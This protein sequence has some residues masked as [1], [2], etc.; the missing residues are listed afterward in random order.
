MKKLFLP[1]IIAIIC[2]NN[3]LKAQCPPNATAFAI[4]YSLCIPEPGCAVLL[5]G[6][7]KG[8]LVNIFGGTP[9]Q[10]I[11]TVQIPGTYPEPG[12]DNAFVC[13][14]CNVPLVFA[15]TV[16]GATNGCVITSTITTPVKLMGFSVN[17]SANGY[18]KIIWSAPSETGTEKYIVE[19]SLDSRTFTELT[20]IIPQRTGTVEHNY[21]YTDKISNQQQLY[22][23]IKTVEINGKI[24]YSE[25]AA[26]KK[27]VDAGVSI[28]PNPVIN[29]FKVNISAQHLPAMVKIFNA[30]GEVVY[31]AKTTSSTLLVKE[32]IKNGVYIIKVIGTDNNYISQKLIVQ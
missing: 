15:S 17:E 24:S 26:V 30:Q 1:T 22:Y 4:N 11:T 29:T 23:R 3:I 9:L 14:P 32:K 28:Y 13:V 7:P 19:R 25:I 16:P 31:T 20:T 21:I 8:V 27:Q 18:Y 10:T 6:W 12:V 5:N 2:V